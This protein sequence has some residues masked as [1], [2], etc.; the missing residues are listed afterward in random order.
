MDQIDDDL[1]A[2][3]EPKVLSRTMGGTFAQQITTKTGT[4]LSETEQVRTCHSYTGI[5]MQICSAAAYSMD[6]GFHSGVD[7]GTGGA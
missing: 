3:H 5:V 7:N 6:A 1:A 4:V 2:R